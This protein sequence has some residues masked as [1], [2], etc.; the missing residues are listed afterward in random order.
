[1]TEQR[2]KILEFV[3]KMLETMPESMVITNW[4]MVRGRNEAMESNGLFITATPSRGITFRIEINGGASSALIS[5]GGYEL[6][7]H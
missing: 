6:V 2:Q 5:E 1:M 7:R 4:G 3:K